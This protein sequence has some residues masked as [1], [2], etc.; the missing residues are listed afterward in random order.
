MENRYIIKQCTLLPNGNEQM[1][2]EG[3]DMTGGNPS[4]Q[5]YESIDSPVI[6]LSIDD[7]IDV[8][9][10][11]SRY[12]ITGG[13]Y[14]ILEIA[15]S[16]DAKRNGQKDF[17]ITGKHKMMLNAVR[18]VRTLSGKQIASFDFVSV[19]AIVNETAKINKRYITDNMS[20]SII[21]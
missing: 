20:S 18:D 2:K 16:E 8:D 13:E 19:E 11:V 10:F 6:S 1:P 4:I 15:L 3:L 12:G 9:Q 7:V 5:Y 17:K 14:L 21:N